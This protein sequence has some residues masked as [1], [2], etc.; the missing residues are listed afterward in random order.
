MIVRRLKR[1][2]ALINRGWQ[3]SVSRYLGRT[4]SEIPEVNF[5][6]SVG[7]SWDE[8]RKSIAEEFRKHPMAFLRQPNISR[9]VHPNQQRIAQVYLEE[10]SQQ[11]FA[12]KRILPRLH[13]LP[14]GDPY[15]CEVFPF[16]SPMTVQHAYYLNFVKKHLGFFIPD[17][18]IDH[19]LELGGGYGNFC[20]LACTFG[21]S[22]RY[23][24]ADL[25]EMHSMQRHY[26]SYSL[27]L[28]MKKNT[29]EFRALED[30][31]ILPEARTSLFLATFSL[32]EMPLE[33]RLEI[34]KYY[35]MF[36]YIFI[37]FNRSFGAVDNCKYFEELKNRIATDFEVNV[38]RDQHRKAWFLV[39]CNHAL[40]S[41]NRR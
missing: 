15:L 13:D 23:I 7:N 9:T 39:G 5:G 34:E 29:P 16:V 1:L 24:I 17:N 3:P 21:Y 2:V 31:E 22:G 30:K 12:Q 28:H 36:G 8:Y 38:I 11:P 6:E 35:K 41:S 32:S 19:I 4:A 18:D 26:L 40:G 33:K 20:R 10:L 27:P 25:P 37:A 14:V